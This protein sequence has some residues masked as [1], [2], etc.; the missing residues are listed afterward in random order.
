M[1]QLARHPRRAPLTTTNK[2]PKAGLT[3]LAQ[4]KTQADIMEGCCC[5]VLG[6]G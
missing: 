2:H 6:P 3:I 5:P 1:G 4:R